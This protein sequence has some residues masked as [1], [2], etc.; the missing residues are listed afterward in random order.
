M[1]RLTAASVLVAAFLVR[2]L[3]VLALVLASVF[4]V[5]VFLLSTFFGAAAFFAVVVDF[6]TAFFGAA[7]LVVAF[8]LVSFSTGS[9]FSAF[10]LISFLVTVAAGFF[11]LVFLANLTGP[12]GPGDV[13]YCQW[14]DIS[15]SLPF[16]WTKSPVS[17]PFFNASLKDLSNIAEDALE[18]LLARTYFLIACR[19]LPF[20]SLS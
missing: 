19:L 14:C 5:S 18:V 12:E 1:N 11:S 8:D 3:A 4:L 2:G 16:C 6:E 10:G 9:A 20:R 15:S 17:T 13:S 7:F